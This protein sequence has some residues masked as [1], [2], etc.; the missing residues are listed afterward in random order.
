MDEPCR[1][2]WTNH[3]VAGILIGL[4][5]YKCCNSLRLV[6]MSIQ[7]VIIWRPCK[8]QGL[9][10]SFNRTIF[11]NHE[12]SRKILG[13]ACYYNWTIV[14]ISSEILVSCHITFIFQIIGILSWENDSTTTPRRRVFCFGSYHSRLLCVVSI[15]RLASFVLRFKPVGSHKV[16][17]I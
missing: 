1:Y 14:Y 17:K 2:Y 3:A 16:A 10:C 8:T 13:L 4:E 15:L 5:F 6:L 12:A 7:M 11:E 9:L